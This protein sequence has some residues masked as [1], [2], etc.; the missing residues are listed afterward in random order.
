MYLRRQPRWTRVAWSRAPPP[1][2]RSHDAACHTTTSPKAAAPRRDDSR[3]HAA[4]CHDDRVPPGPA[5]ATRCP[6]T[7]LERLKRG[8]RPWKVER[9]RETGERGRHA[10]EDRRE[11]GRAM[12][13]EGR[14]ALLSGVI[15][16]RQEN[17]GPVKNPNSPIYISLLESG[18]WA[19]ATRL[20]YF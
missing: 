6:T 11:R 13:W 10:R 19:L 1:A 16:E 14:S 9:L 3:L 8:R 12:R 7:R 18:L 4:P 17:K 2:A 5:V 15:R 20:Q